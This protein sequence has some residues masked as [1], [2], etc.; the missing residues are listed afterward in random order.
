MDVKKLLI[1]AAATT[2]SSCTTHGEIN[3][4]WVREQSAQNTTIE[5]RMRSSDLSRIKKLQIYFYINVF[6]CDFPNDYYPMQPI[7]DGG[8]GNEFEFRPMG[9]FSNI[10]G[11]LPTNIFKKYRSACL[12]VNGGSYSR[13]RI[14]TNTVKINKRQR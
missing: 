12:N 10:N 8:L 7:I 9:S 14:T 2:L 5:L 3:S 11:R 4:A 1:F 13:V 6:D